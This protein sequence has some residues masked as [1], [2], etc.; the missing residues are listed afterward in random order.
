[1]SGQMAMRDDRFA[2]NDRPS[3]LSVAH[4]QPHPVD[5]HRTPVTVVPG[6]LYILEIGAELE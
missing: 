5:L 1:M 4:V 6:V 3:P 2:T